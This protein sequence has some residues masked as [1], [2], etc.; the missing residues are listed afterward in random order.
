MTNLTKKKKIL[1]IIGGAVLLLA[2]LIGIWHF[3][4]R[5]SDKADS[6]NEVYTTSIA[7][8]TAST[9]GASNRFAGVVEPQQTI[10]IQK[11]T[12]RKIKE[13]FVKEG[14][15]VI[16]GAPLFSYDTDETQMKLSEAELELERIT[17]EISTL[18]GQ[19]EMLE[20]E[21]AKAP[22]SE[23]FSYTTQILTAQNDAKRAEYNQ[24]SK[25]VEIEQIRKSLQNATVTSDID[26]VVKSI[27]DGTT[28]SYDGSTDSSYMTILSN[29]EYRIK[30]KINE[31]NMAS[32]T[33]GQPMLIHSRTDDTLVWT[34]TV[35]EVDTENPVSNNNSNMYMS[36]S[37]DTNTTSSSY[38][39]YVEIEA[40]APLMLGQHVFM[41]PDMGQTEIKEGLW[42]PSYYLVIDGNDAYVWVAGKKDKLEKRKITTGEHDEAM[43][44]YQITSG[45]S[46]DDYIAFPDD[47]LSAGMPCIKDAG[48]S[49]GMS[50]GEDVSGMGGASYEG[51]ISVMEETAQ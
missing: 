30:G 23:A 26:G 12:D 50:G 19:I 22:E 8:L 44:E 5:K 36:G 20:K 14:D 11:A 45:L 46:T 28:Q 24:K 15:T 31:Q 10:K 40:N 43:D 13:V 6:G 39:F 34:G 41:E 47:T 2:I 21:K 33:T 18:Y 1:F 27:N 3:F 37:T 4:F 51:E 17:G 35:T 32:I 38:N 42:L 29:K 9:S 25:S 49:S 48:M 7:L 16:K